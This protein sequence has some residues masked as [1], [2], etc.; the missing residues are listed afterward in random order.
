MRG[1]G[2]SREKKLKK[3]W[4]RKRWSGFGQGRA[5]RVIPGSKWMVRCTSYWVGFARRPGWFGEPDHGAL[6]GW[7]GEADR[8]AP[9]VGWVHFL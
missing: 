9:P 8:V 7:L 1:G 2:G 5:V 3:K 4:G 6:P